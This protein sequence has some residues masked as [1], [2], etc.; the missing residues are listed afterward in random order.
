M[1]ASGEKLRCARS[2]MRWTLIRL[3]SSNSLSNSSLSAPLLASELD[4]LS[5]SMNDLGVPY[6]V[7]QTDLKLLVRAR[8]AHLVQAEVLLSLNLLMRAAW[9]NVATNERSLPVRS[10]TWISQL[11]QSILVIL[12]PRMEGEVPQMDDTDLAEAAF[13]LAYYSLSPPTYETVVAIIRPN[14]GGDQ[15]EIGEIEIK[16]R[17]PI[18]RINGLG[19]GTLA[20]TG[21]S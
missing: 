11:S 7:P 13:G 6:P 15:I 19:N 17:Q 3:Y 8:G 20:G 9:K 21:T 4:A 1:A 16:R 12:R 14:E 2:E 5:P 18:L 10:R